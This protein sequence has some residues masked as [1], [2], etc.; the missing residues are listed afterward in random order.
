MQ[1]KSAVVKNKEKEIK[2]ER[3]G[4]KLHQTRKMSHASEMQQ[5]SRPFLLVNI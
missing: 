5:E 4:M 3:S 1:L 2:K